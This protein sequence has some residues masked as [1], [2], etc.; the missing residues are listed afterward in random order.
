MTVQVQETVFKHTANGVTTTFAYGCLVLLD[1]DL[2][3]LLDGVV[4]STGYTVQDIGNETGGTVTFSIAPANEVAVVLQRLLPLNRETDYQQ[5]GDWKASVINPDIDRLVMIAQQQQEQIDRSLSFPVGDAA[6]GA[7]IPALAERAGKLL[8]FGPDGNTKVFTTD[9]ENVVAA[10]A[11]ADDA[12]AAAAQ[13]LAALAAAGLPAS[14]IGK[15]LNYLRVKS[16]ASGYEFRTASQMRTDLSAA[17][18]GANSDI[19]S[20]TGLTGQVDFAAAVSVSS[21]TTVDLGA[22]ASNNVTITGTTSIASL[23]NAA[24]GIQRDVTFTGALTLTHNGAS[25]ILPGGANITT[26]AGD[27]ATFVSLGSG[28]WRCTSYQ[29]A[30]G[31]PVA[32]VL[33]AGQTRQDV[34]AS[35]VSGTIY[36]NSTGRPILVSVRGTAA[37]VSSIIA[38]VGG[39]SGATATAGSAGVQLAIEFIVMAGETYKV[40]ISNVGSAQWL[41]VR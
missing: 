2:Q 10:Q 29:K 21:A 31:L 9:T 17:A 38:T 18:S 1:S 41:E 33:G 23:G 22:K 5:H 37:G 7:A 14:L 4:Q 20:L 3:V 30:S 15:A 32:G 11:A 36:T 35:R 26:A 24:A 25:L 27:T 39:F 8:G 16:D 13:V 28:Q 34:L 19:A 12:E 40:D 6:T